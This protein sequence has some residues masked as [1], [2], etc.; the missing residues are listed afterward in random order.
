V[1]NETLAESRNPV[2]PKSAVTSDASSQD[3]MSAGAS[4]WRGRAMTQAGALA[5]PLGLARTAIEANVT[6]WSYLRQEGEAA[7]AHLR[8]LR[9]AKSPA[10]LM[11][12]QASEMA[13][14]LGSALNLGQDL[15]KSAGLIDKEPSSGSE[16]K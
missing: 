15:A 7:L 9:G 10:Q 12:L 16:E 14:A 5:G 1:A 6:V 11:E 13:R 2:S 4:S 8:A 3:G